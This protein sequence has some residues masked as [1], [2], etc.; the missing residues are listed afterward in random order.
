[1]PCTSVDSAPTTS[2]GCEAGCENG[3]LSERLYIKLV[4]S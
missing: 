4:G 3:R 2:E 1:M